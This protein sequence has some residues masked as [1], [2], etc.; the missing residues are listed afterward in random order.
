MRLTIVADKAVDPLIRTLGWVADNGETAQADLGRRAPDPAEAGKL[1]RRIEGLLATESRLAALTV[2]EKQQIAVALSDAHDIVDRV[3]ADAEY[4]G[5]DDP[6]VIER[7][8]DAI[9]Y[10]KLRGQSVIEGR[11]RARRAR[12]TKKPNGA[13]P[14]AS[15]KPASD[16]PA[17]DKPTG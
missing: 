3:A 16:E 12:Q 4:H 13:K 11:E 8:G 2:A 7:Y 5:Q 17:S 9:G 6:A 15:D 10:R 14:A 1:A